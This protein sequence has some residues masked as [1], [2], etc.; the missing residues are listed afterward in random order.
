MHQMLSRVY[1]KYHRMFDTLADPSME[2]SIHRILNIV[3]QRFMYEDV[4][5]QM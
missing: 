2:N 5:D 1:K 3:N 4:E